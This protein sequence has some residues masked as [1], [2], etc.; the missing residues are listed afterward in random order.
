M[1][2][3]KLLVVSSAL[4]SSLSASEDA[5]IPNATVPTAPHAQHEDVIEFGEGVDACLSIAQKNQ[6]KLVELAKKVSRGRARCKFPQNAGIP[7]P[8]QQAKIQALGE[9]LEFN[10]ELLG[11]ILPLVPEVMK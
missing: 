6:E 7:Y 5:L 2:M 8:D 10:E 9:M 1:N 4:I 3:K 11:Y